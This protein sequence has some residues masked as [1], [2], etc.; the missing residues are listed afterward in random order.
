MS[1][2]IDRAD[3]GGLIVRSFS[4]LLAAWRLVERKPVNEGFSTHCQSVVV[5]DPARPYPPSCLICVTHLVGDVIQLA[6]LYRT[7][8]SRWGLTILYGVRLI[9]QGLWAGSTRKGTEQ[10]ELR[11]LRADRL[12]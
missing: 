2:L 4:D 12:H 9:G 5:G 10:P 3:A 6:S 1:L 7:G 11:L 8:H